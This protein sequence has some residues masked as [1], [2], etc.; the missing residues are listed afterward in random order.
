MATQ[1]DSVVLR[2]LSASRLPRASSFSSRSTSTEQHADTAAEGASV[3][4]LP[5]D[6]SR[7]HALALGGTRVLA[8]PRLPSPLPLSLP[9]QTVRP[10]K[11]KA[12]PPRSVASAVGKRMRVEGIAGGH[13]PSSLEL[14]WDIVGV[15]CG[16]HPAPDTPTDDILLGPLSCLSGGQECWILLQPGREL[17]AFSAARLQETV[18]QDTGTL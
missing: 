8:S 2:A 16:R 7:G 13:A 4:R 3:E 14:S 6:W 15:A 9:L 1:S 11:R 10:L 12:S 17:F 18:S 5:L